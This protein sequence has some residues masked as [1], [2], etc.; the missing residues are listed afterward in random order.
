MKKIVI[1]PGHGGR[2]P[3]A[4]GP[5]GVQEKV[6]TLAVA[7]KLEEI[8]CRNFLVKMTRENDGTVSLTRRCDIANS[9]RA[10]IFVSIH[11]NAFRKRTAKGTETYCYPGSIKGR[12]LAIAVQKEL[13]KTLKL[14][15]RGVKEA[16]FFVLRKTV[17]PAILVELG[18]ISNLKEESL[19]ENPAFQEKAALAI[20]NGIY[21]YKLKGGY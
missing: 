18:F 11:C 6:V 3:G 7:R 13:V 5:T 15:D 20:A 19:L 1:D 10:D 17:M 8:L 9:W 2:D 21:F 14:P 12:E 16:R 4:V